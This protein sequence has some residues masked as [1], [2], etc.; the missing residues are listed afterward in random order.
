MKKIN[1]NGN[2]SWNFINFAAILVVSVNPEVIL[3]PKSR[4]NSPKHCAAPIEH[5]QKR[6]Q[7]NKICKFNCKVTHIFFYNEI[8]GILLQIDI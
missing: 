5:F 3:R 1:L 4:Y 2:T 7:E 8:M 6:R